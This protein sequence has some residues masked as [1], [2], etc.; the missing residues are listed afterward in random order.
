MTVYAPTC[1]VNAALSSAKQGDF[2]DPKN[3]VKK[4]DQ[5]FLI[6]NVVTCPEFHNWCI[7]SQN[8]SIYCG[9][10]VFLCL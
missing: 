9:K 2:F 5:L 1:L 10:C 4:N 8:D 7:P 3:E 6:L